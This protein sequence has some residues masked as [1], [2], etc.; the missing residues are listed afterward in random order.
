MNRI[1][2]TAIIGGGAAGFFLAINL[3]ERCP[4]M[5]VVIME[6]AQRVLRKVEISGGG[7]CN[8]TN[9]FEDIRDLREVYPRGHRLLGRLFRE[10]DHRAVWQW[11]E[12]RGVKLVAQT[13]HCVFPQSQDAH[14]IVNLFLNEAHRLGIEVVTGCKIQSL[15]ELADYDYLCVTTGG[16]PRSEQL[17]WLQQE[18]VEPV[19][20]LFSFSIADDRLHQLMGAVAEHAQAMIPGMRL[21]SAGPLLITHWGMSGPCI[22]RLSSYAARQL[23]EADY[24]LPL[25][26]NW[27]GASEDEV[28]E[29]ITGM[30]RQHPQKLVTSVAPLQLSQR[31]W[32]YLAEKAI[33]QRATEAPLGS[34]NAKE[35]R[36]LVAA[37]VADQYH[38]SG[39]APHRD[40][41]VTC[42]GISLSSVNPHTL[43]SR[44][45]PALY[46][47][48]EV[49]D[50][51]GVTGGFNFQA[52][53]TTAYTVAR[54]I[55]SL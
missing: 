9:T 42:G 30:M 44:T 38:I 26:V 46:F 50:I 4:Q 51:D 37:V 20:S 15:D 48:G 31:L 36:R 35:Q 19:P 25:Q 28:A 17:S 22:L 13:D 34:L 43:E 18:I 53:W 16:Q 21:R 2:R 49:L 12:Q 32:C 29:A 39:R 55:A 45:R 5:E 47:A 52:A 40:E 7:R 23:H 11:F 6:R 1:K 54:S 41:F 10:F 14:T 24:Q 3:K 33:A 8:V 27:V